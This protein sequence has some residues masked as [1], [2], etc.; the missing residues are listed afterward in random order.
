MV[1]RDRTPFKRKRVPSRLEH[2]RSEV[3]LPGQ[4]HDLTRIVGVSPH[5]ARVSSR[6]MIS[7]APRT[8]DCTDGWAGDAAER[9]RKAPVNRAGYRDA[10]RRLKLHVF[11]IHVI[12]RTHRSTT[13]WFAATNAS[14]SR[15]TRPAMRATRQPGQGQANTYRE[16][17]PWHEFTLRDDLGQQRPDQYVTQNSSVGRKASIE[18]DAFD[19][20]PDE[21]N[22]EA[23]RSREQR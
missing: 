19:D 21:R 13:T 2:T 6:V 16:K 14:A 3:R 23:R 10:G 12:G 7:T 22:W 17:A 8:R 15:V 11:G 18:S 4:L 5:A 20:V 1:W 9:P